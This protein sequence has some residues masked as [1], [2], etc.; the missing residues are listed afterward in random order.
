MK[1]S[2]KVLDEFKAEFPEAKKYIEERL[3]EECA[4]KNI[5]VNKIIFLFTYWEAKS[6]ALAQEKRFLFCGAKF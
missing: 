5:S 1:I 6:K 4:K 3:E 2:L